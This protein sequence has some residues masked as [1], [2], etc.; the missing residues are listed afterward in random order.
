MVIAT[1][2]AA[3]HL[4]NVELQSRGEVIAHQRTH[5]VL[6]KMVSDIDQRLDEIKR[7]IEAGVAT[8]AEDGTLQVV[9][10]GNGRHPT[11]VHPGGSIK[12][13]RLAEEAAAKEAA[14]VQEVKEQKP[15][16]KVPRRKKA[17]RGKGAEA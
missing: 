1:E 7:A 15:T 9:S 17:S 12:E 5:D 10:G 13:Q 14:A 16:K 4:E 2:N 3:D 6:K 8:V 11:G